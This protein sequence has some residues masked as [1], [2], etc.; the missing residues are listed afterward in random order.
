M[1]MLV[2]MIM[3]AVFVGMVIVAAV[4]V[5]PWISVRAKQSRVARAVPLSISRTLT[6]G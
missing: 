2:G 4:V 6:I 3:E 1:I 5:S